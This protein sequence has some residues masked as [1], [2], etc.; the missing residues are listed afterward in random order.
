MHNIPATQPSFTYADCLTR[1]TAKQT[2][3]CGTSTSNTDQPLRVITPRVPSKTPPPPTPA[4]P[5]T[6]NKLDGAGRC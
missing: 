3:S 1:V 4:L 2:S 6:A 5:T